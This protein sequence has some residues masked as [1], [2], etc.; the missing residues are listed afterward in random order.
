MTGSKVLG[1]KAVLKN[2]WF[3]LD[4]SQN[5]AIV[6]YNSFCSNPRIPMHRVIVLVLSAA[7]AGMSL[8]PPASLRCSCSSEPGG[9][10][11]SHMSPASCCKK[12][13][14][15]PGCCTD[16]GHPESESSPKAA[17]LCFCMGCSDQLHPVTLVSHHDRSGSSRLQFADLWQE[18]C[19][20]AVHALRSHAAAAF[21]KK[22]VPLPEAPVFLRTCSFLI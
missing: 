12:S 14:N 1:I 2:L 13:R 5:P 8:F 10:A 17:T 3:F 16:T 22:P 9:R 20:D 19:L 7:L 15:L 18:A 21:S 6:V 4:L 11:E